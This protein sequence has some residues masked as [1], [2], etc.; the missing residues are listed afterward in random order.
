MNRGLDFYESLDY[1][2]VLSPLSD[3]DGGGWLAEHPELPG[4]ASDGATPEEALLNLKD[5]RWAWLRVALER[6]RSIPLPQKYQVEEYSG[7]FTLRL[8]RSMHRKLAELAEKE[9]VSL[10]QMVLSLVSY[11]LGR[12][13]GTPRVEIIA[14]FRMPERNDELPESF[15]VKSN[16]W[17]HF[18]SNQWRHCEGKGRLSYIPQ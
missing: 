14:E 18:K 10:N 8:P 1:R 6:G 16:Q 12:R 9:G 5:A 17:R 7:K 11:G 4:C 13:A 15:Y 2:V 3:E